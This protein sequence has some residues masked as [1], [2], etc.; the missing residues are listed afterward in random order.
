MRN[1]S[2]SKVLYVLEPLCRGYQHSQFNGDYLSVLLSNKEF[3]QI[4]FFAEKD[5]LNSV[6]IDQSFVHRIID[7]RPIYVSLTHRWTDIFSNIQ[8]LFR[9][10]MI[11]KNSKYPLLTLSCNKFLFVLLGLCSLL[12]RKSIIIFL[13]NFIFELDKRPNYLFNLKS[14]FRFFKISKMKYIVLGDF[15][16]QNMLLILPDL[17]SNLY[18]LDLILRE[19]NSNGYLI[20]SLTKNSEVE[21][22]YVIGSAGVFSDSKGSLNFL[23]LVKDLKD[24]PQFEFKYAGNI[25]VC[26]LNE[27]NLDE[28]AFKNPIRVQTN[29]EYNQIFSTFDFLILFYP[30]FLYRLGFSGIFLDLLKHEI[31]LVAIHNDFFDFY[32]SKYGKLGWLFE[33]YDSLLNHLLIMDDSFV[34]EIEI[35]KGN[36]RRARKDFDASKVNDELMDV[37]NLE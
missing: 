24:L 37:I 31:P 1:S 7:F 26:I 19:E 9:I 3:D 29:S 23:R 13:H 33:D 17:R 2:K 18:S 28:T 16:K 10:L 11:S 5:H 20:S 4:V 34:S 6:P 14:I 21:K 22:K 15:V 35:I 30:K 36:I 8:I 32:F 12:T 27:H 25:D